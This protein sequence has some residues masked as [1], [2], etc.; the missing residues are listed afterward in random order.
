[1]LSAWC[2][3]FLFSSVLLCGSVYSVRNAVFYSVVFVVLVVC[4]LHCGQYLRQVGLQGTEII[5]NCTL[6]CIR[7]TIR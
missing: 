5:A 4:A 6:R 3:I 2:Y 1:M 7:K